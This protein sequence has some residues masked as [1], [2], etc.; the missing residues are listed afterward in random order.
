MAHHSSLSATSSQH[1]NDFPDIVTACMAAA[2][3]QIEPE[4]KV[5]VVMH[6]GINRKATKKTFK[7]VK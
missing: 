5:V 4:E 1:F 3:E 6:I 2:E 7:L